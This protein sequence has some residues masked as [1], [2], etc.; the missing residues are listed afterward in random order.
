MSRAACWSLEFPRSMARGR[1]LKYEDRGPRGYR[2]EARRSYDETASGDNDKQEPQR[3][4]RPLR[5][6]SSRTTSGTSSGH[7]S[8]IDSLLQNHLDRSSAYS[9]LPT[10]PLAARP[11][12]NDRYGHP[13]KL[14]TSVPASG[15]ASSADEP[16][17]TRER[18][19]G[20]RKE[21]N[22]QQTGH[23]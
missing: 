3:D 1:E 7:G 22:K 18:A 19:P 9:Q 20:G 2:L 10:A 15:R 23:D 13:T 4:C 17:Q 8:N 12:V 16:A 14:S 11:R 21:G 6:I 5:D